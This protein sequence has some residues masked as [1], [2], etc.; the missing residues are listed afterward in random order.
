MTIDERIESVTAQMNTVQQQVASVDRQIVQ[1]QS[2]REQLV[3]MFHQHQGALS[4]LQELKA[5]QCVEQPP[6]GSE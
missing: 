2:Q 4:L 3:L 5:D 6:G 1:L